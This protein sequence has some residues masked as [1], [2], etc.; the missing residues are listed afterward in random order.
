MHC[1]LHIRRHPIV[2]HSIQL[3]RSIIAENQDSV[4]T[5]FLSTLHNEWKETRHFPEHGEACPSSLDFARDD[6]F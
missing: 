5:L 1:L 6:G 4:D 2:R 3:R